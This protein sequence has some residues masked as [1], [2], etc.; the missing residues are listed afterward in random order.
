V[1]WRRIF[2]FWKEEIK[3]KLEKEESI[4]PEVKNKEYKLPELFMPEVILS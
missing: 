1:N 2:K 4:F 3:L